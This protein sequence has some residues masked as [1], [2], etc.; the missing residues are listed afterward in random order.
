MYAC[1]SVL[2]N[3]TY[4]KKSFYAMTCFVW[5]NVPP[6]VSPVIIIIIK[7]KKQREEIFYNNQFKNRRVYYLCFVFD[8][9]YWHFLQGVFYKCFINFCDSLKKTVVKMYSQEQKVK[10]KRE[11]CFIIT[12][13]DINWKASFVL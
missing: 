6:L 5:S 9:L 11:Y 3:T 10:I 13:T 4:D 8:T 1:K 7:H 12:P 2:P